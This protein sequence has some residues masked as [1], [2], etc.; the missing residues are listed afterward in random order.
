MERSM[1]KVCEHCQQP[2]IRFICDARDGGCDGSGGHWRMTAYFDA[3]GDD[4]HWI[5]CRRCGGEGKM[6][7]CSNFHCPGKRR[8]MA[9]ALDQ[10]ILK[11]V[12][13]E[14]SE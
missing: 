13:G 5:A 6:T 12:N 11:A 14:G 10:A 8:Y 4:Y 9:S 2:M 1:T 3:R 7:A